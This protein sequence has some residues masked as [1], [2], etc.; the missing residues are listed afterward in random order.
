MCHSPKDMVPEH[1]FYNRDDQTSLHMPRKTRTSKKK[2][3]MFLSVGF[4][5][6]PHKHSQ[7]TK[8]T[9]RLHPLVHSNTIS[10]H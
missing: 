3:P 2:Y 4:K 6:E 8:L 10:I 5:P 7:P 1:F 9:A